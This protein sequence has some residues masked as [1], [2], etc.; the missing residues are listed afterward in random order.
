VDRATEHGIQSL[1]SKAD[2]RGQ[3]EKFLRTGS[4]RTFLWVYLV[5]KY[6]RVEKNKADTSAGPWTRRL[7]RLLKDVDDAYEQLFAGPNNIS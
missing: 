6:L 3:L 7:T 1:T 5:F 2:E 4:Q